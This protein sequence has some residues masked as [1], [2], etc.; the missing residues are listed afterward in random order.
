MIT[1]EDLEQLPTRLQE[2]VKALQIAKDNATSRSAQVYERANRAER[3]LEG[4]KKS[5]VE[6]AVRYL[7]DHGPCSDVTDILDNL[8]LSLPSKRVSF[9]VVTR[10]VVTFT[11][12]SDD[13]PEDEDFLRNLVSIDSDGTVTVYG[14]DSIEDIDITDGDIDGIEDIELIEN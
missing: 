1:Q 9:T 7:R 13:D 4:F 10:T 11:V 3:E 6:E 5:V 14:S 12:T 2:E 8:G